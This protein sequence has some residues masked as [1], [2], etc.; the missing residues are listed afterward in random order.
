MRK[1]IMQSAFSNKDPE[2]ALVIYQ[3]LLRISNPVQESLS[4]ACINVPEGTNFPL[5]SVLESLIPKKGSSLIAENDE[6]FLKSQIRD[7]CLCCA[8]LASA[9]GHAGALM[10]SI[11]NNLSC[12][13][14][15][16]FRELSETLF[17]CPDG[18]LSK[19][20]SSEC[21]LVVEMM[22]D[23]LP[24]LQ[25]MIK[26]SSISSEADDIVAAS[27]RIPVGSAILA[28]YQFRWIVTKVSKP[29]LG[30]LCALILP[31]ALTALDHWSPEVKGQAMVSFIYM[32]KNI[33]AAELGCYK[34]VI[35]DAAYRNIPSCD[36]LWNY[37]VEM[38]VLLL[39]GTQ[40][41]NPRSPWFEKILSEMLGHLE[42]QPKN[43]D[44]RIAWLEL[45]DQVFY[46]RSLFLL[47]HFRQLFPLFFQWMH[48]EDDKTVILVLERVHLILKLTWIR[49][50]QYVER[51]VDEL[52][53]VY[54]E[55]AIRKDRETIRVHIVHTLVLLHNCM[56][57]HLEA[58]WEKHKD[59]SNLT[60]LASSFKK[61]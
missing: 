38:C 50:T 6:S 19:T 57:P 20:M 4:K 53:L 37:V 44:R 30:R 54:K 29:H 13:A 27:S 58:A 10:S 40:E 25:K 55:S 1:S 5:K 48:A 49:K 59:D 36:E 32:M 14:K 18:D 45:I 41:G 39:K 60:V 12:A 8:G 9:E 35:L 51:L 34:D 28:A 26:D 43:I 24:F 47:A 17:S 31:C 7:F 3:N 61:E 11:P 23:L 21:D 33:K 16:A 42:R 15:V 56:R 52:V 2:C 22:P 46:V